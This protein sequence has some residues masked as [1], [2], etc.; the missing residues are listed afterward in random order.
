[1]SPPRGT[2]R[3]RFERHASFSYRRDRRTRP[4]AVDNEQ[5]D[6]T[7]AIGIAV[8]D[9]AEVDAATNVIDIV[10]LGVGLANAVDECSN[11]CAEPCLF[12]A[13]YRIVFL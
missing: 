8:G 9:A 5:V 2:G 11:R 12:D 3:F 4:V 6:V 1:M 7:L 10:N 13:E